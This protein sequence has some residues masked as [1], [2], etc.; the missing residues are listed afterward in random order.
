MSQINKQLT[1]RDF[2]KGVGVIAG[3]V[4][5][6][7]VLGSCAQPA[8]QAT[9]APVIATPTIVKGMVVDKVEPISVLINDSPWFPGFEKLVKLIRGKDRQSSKPGRNPVQRYAGENQ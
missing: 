4:V 8:P 3:S 2:L 5:A 7:S 1:R 6:S 9:Q